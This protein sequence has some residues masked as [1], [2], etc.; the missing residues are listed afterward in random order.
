LVNIVVLTKKVS[1]YLV[2]QFIRASPRA[3]TSRR[4]PVAAQASVSEC[5]RST[6]FKKKGFFHVISRISYVRQHKILSCTRQWCSLALH[7]SSWCSIALDGVT[8]PSMALHGPQWCFM[9]LHGP[10]WP[11]M[12]LHGPP[13]PSMALHGP[14]WPSMAL[15]G[16]SWPSMAPYGDP[17]PSIVF[18][19]P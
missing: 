19:G 16:V 7:C 6:L 18:H 17:W 4:R 9:A 1:C 8:W 12:A 13:W 3:A 14:P 15:N 2:F 10:P 5:G 11:S